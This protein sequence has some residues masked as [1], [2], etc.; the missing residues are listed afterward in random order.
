MSILKFTLNENHLK[1][2]KHLA[3]GELKDGVI[4]TEGKTPFGGF[5]HYDD[6]ATI[7]Y[8][9]PENHNPM[10]D[11]PHEWSDEQIK[12]MDDLL[13]QLP[14]AIEVVLSTQSFELG[15]YKSKWHIR[16]WKKI[17]N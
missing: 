14:M 11:E 9:K 6:M 4:S 10:T 13:Q 1:L 2:I 17:D 12:E 7:L 8:G 16:E 5:D 3:W 15:L